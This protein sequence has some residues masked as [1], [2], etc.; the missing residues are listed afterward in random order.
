MTKLQKDTISNWVKSAEFDRDTV[1]DLFKLK[2]YGWSLFIFHLAIEKLLKAHLVKR[3]IV[4][5]YTHNLLRLADLTKIKYTATQEKYFSEIMTFNIQA[6]YDIE[7]MDFYKK[8]D[9]KYTEKWIKI[10][11]N[12]FEWLRE[13]L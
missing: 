10:C 4:I 12:I 11:N 5:P 1:F 3:E 2:H 6:R 9:K 7:K 13:L 8:A